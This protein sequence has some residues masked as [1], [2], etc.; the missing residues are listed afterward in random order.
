MPSL[1]GNGP[2]NGSFP[3]HLGASR[4]DLKPLKSGAANVPTVN[5]IF[6]HAAHSERPTDSVSNSFGEA[7][8][9]HFKGQ[10]TRKVPYQGRYGE[11]FTLG[12]ESIVRG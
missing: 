10:C 1:R 11:E 7:K 2:V 4:G 9:G 5:Q 8:P 6:R 3:K 12:H